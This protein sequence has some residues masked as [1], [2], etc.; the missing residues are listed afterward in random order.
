MCSS[1]LAKV[2]RDEKRARQEVLFRRVLDRAWRMQFY[3]RLWGRKGIARGDIRGLDDLPKLPMFDKA[4]IVESVRLAP[5][6]GDFPGLDS[7]DAGQR[8]PVIFHTT[9][10]TTG[11]PQPL[12]FGPK[13]REVQN[14]LL[15]RLYRLQGLRPEEIGRAHV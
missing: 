7:Y 12:F 2:S 15:G 14:L 3:Q 11:K 1:D 5:P 10:G 13:T 4:D 9:S 8:P 6:F